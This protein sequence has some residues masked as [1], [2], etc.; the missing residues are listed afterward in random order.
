MMVTKVKKTNCPPFEKMTKLLR[1]VYGCG[2]TESVCEPHD[3]SAKA[4]IG[5]IREKNAN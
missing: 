2:E 5:A 1:R 4:M 3:A